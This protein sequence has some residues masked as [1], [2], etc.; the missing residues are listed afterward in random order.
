MVLVKRPAFL[1]GIFFYSAAACQACN[2]LY[3]YVTNFSESIRAFFSNTRLNICSMKHLLRI[4]LLCTGYLY[5]SA[6]APAEKALLWKISGQNL[7]HPSY[8][9]GTFHLM[10]PRDLIVSDTIRHA[11]AQTQQLYM[12]LDISDPSIQA[13]TLQLMPMPASI[14]L[15]KLID[16]KDYDS[17]SAIFNKKTGMPFLLF[18]KVKPFFTTAMLY[19]AMMGCTP[20]GWE[21][22]FDAMAKKRNIPVKG[23]ETVAFQMGLFDA[24]PYREQAQELV[25]TLYHF[26]SA[27]KASRQLVDLY[28]Q[29]D[30]P[31]MYAAT[32]KDTS[33]HRFEEVLLHKRNTSWIPV[34]TAA[35]QA[36]PSFIAVG[37]AHLGGANGVISL[38]RKKGYRLTPVYY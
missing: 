37:A 9:Y 35:I 22:V 38:L 20:K 23:L 7:P 31:G 32:I 8:L 17:A 13:Q 15:D 10:C 26:D 6:Q 25:E 5:S 21:S 28:K 29:K 3:Y 19:P 11:F 30:L 27:Q 4:L 16:K 14:S 1:R 33:F 24:V 18:N 2:V 36:T 12:E 34:I